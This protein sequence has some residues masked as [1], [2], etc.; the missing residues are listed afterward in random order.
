M[1]CQELAKGKRVTLF[2][3]NLIY[4]RYGS[5]G[6]STVI[7]F[8]GVSVKPANLASCSSNLVIIAQSLA[9]WS[10]G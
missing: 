5:T 7:S 8:C 1:A 4:T 3:V 9:S 10:T 6:M 2:A